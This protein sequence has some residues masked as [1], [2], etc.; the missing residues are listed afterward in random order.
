MPNTMTAVYVGPIPH[1]VLA[2]GD[3]VARQGKHGGVGTVLAVTHKGG[4]VSGLVVA[5]NSNDS[6]SVHFAPDASANV[7]SMYNLRITGFMVGL[8]MLNTSFV[9]VPTTKNTPTILLPR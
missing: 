3:R 5:F 7:E 9:S 1:R 2:V 6:V 4:I 8:G